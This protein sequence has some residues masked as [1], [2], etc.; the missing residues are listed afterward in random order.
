MSGIIYLITLSKLLNKFLE[1]YPGILSGCLAGLLVLDK[2]LAE[3]FSLIE[4]GVHE[5]DELGIT[6]LLVRLKFA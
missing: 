1:A 2:N 6:V 3:A 4:D 5:G